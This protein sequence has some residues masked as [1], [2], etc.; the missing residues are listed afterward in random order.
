MSIAR[1]R[2]DR[3]R[4]VVTGMGV[5]SPCGLN[6]EAF[7]AN[8]VEGRSGVGPIT[9]FDTTNYASKIAGEVK[10]FDGEDY[11]SRKEVRRM[12]LFSQYAIGASDQVLADAQLNGACDPERLGVI[13]GSGIGGFWTIEQQHTTLLERGPRRVSPFFIPMMIPDMSS[14]LISIRAC[15][16]GPNY[17]TVSACASGAH[18]IGDAMMLIERGDADVML[19]GGAEA[20]ITPMAVSGFASMRALSRRNDE[21][22]RASRPFDAKRDGFVIAEGAGMLV[23]EDAEFARARGARIYAEIAGVGYTAD[24]FDETMPPPD[25]DGARRAMELAL[26]DARVSPEDVDYINAHATSTPGGDEREVKAMRAVFGDGL[27]R[28]AVSS[29]KGTTGHLLGAAGPLELIAAILAI[30]TGTIPPTINYDSADPECDISPTP[31]RAVKRKG[32]VAL[33]N[34]FGFGGHNASIVVIHPM[35]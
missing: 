13:C 24:A 26:R 31:N 22:E 27:D 11:L 5:I 20:P 4:V 12:D 28:I 25:G 7:W 21:P 33:S 2:E 10:G 34:S 29:T 9:R 15:A 35:S 16:K 14:G 32:R 1:D 6:L 18:A 3:P 23:L 19:A 8:L 17:T 30:R